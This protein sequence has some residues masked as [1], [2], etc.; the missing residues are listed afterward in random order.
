MLSKCALANRTL[1]DRM[2][3]VAK[4]MI[5]VAAICC[6]GHAG[7]S[8]PDSKTDLFL[9]IEP[10]AQK[11]YELITTKPM[12]RA[13]MKVTDIDRL[14][15]VWEPEEREQAR[16]ATPQQRRQMTFERY[17]WVKRVG[18]EQPGLPLGYT[19]DGNGMLAINCFSCHGG[20]VAGKT[21]PGAGNTHVDL[22][23]IGTDLSKLAVLDAGGD[24]DKA[25]MPLPFPVNYHKGFT[26]A[27]VIEVMNYVRLNP[28]AMIKVAL[29]PGI[30]KHHDMNPP[31]W[32]TTK[33]KA[34]LYVDG[35]APKTPRQNM[36]FARNMD[37]PDWEQKW[38]ALEPD[39]VHIYQYIEELE[40]P[41]YPFEIDY[42][43]AAAGQELFENTCAECHGTYG[44]NPD[45]RNVIVPVNEVGTDPV[46]LTAVPRSTREWAN[47]RW[48][49]YY[50]QQL[51]KLE[52]K[53]YL[54]PPLDGV[55]ASAPYFH[56]GA[57]PT[58]ADVMNSAERPKVWKR[59]ED[60]YDQVKV[61]LEVE[62][63]DSVPEGL[64]S[65][66]RRMYYDTSHVG[67]SNAGH[68][69]P[70]VLSPDEKLAVI[71]YLKTL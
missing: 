30:L 46:R 20:K 63:F 53:G 61:G 52:S 33:R 27:V 7:A 54:A 69:F 28:Q 1:A 47:Q 51:I 23:T 42:Q 29:N 3:F 50:G 37:Q 68:T 25:G 65:R 9:G 64:S 44:D 48:M 18:D 67:N 15:T 35:F 11:G 34:R 14:W 41:K 21:M 2:R 4:S 57:A 12:G 6:G 43:L 31:A 60:G 16:A 36:P 13:V 22:T 5:V 56:N 55:W 39:F 59:T 19:E 62:T 45:F 8:D 58:L 26:N 10:D 70:D 17:G 38:Q 24:P 40:A 71:E 49:Q 66:I 32:W